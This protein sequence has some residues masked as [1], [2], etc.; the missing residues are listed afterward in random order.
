VDFD[1]AIRNPPGGGDDGTRLERDYGA[2][3]G[4]IRSRGTGGSGVI[5]GDGFDRVAIFGSPTQEVPE[6]AEQGGGVLA[7]RA[8]RLLPVRVVCRYAR[9][10]SGMDDG[11]GDT[12]HLFLDLVADVHHSTDHEDRDEGENAKEDE[13]KR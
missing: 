10:W 2:F 11:V 3:L 6:V 4:W 8:G 5:L 13:Q 7:S 12:G 1:I 9:G